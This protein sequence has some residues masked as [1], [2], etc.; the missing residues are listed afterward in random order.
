[1]RHLGSLLLS[2]VGGALIYVLI[3]IGLIKWTDGFD[4]GDGKDWAAFGIGLAAM[5]GAGALYA[6]LVLAR[7]SPL[8]LVLLGLLFLAIP[9]WGF[10][11]DS[12]FRDVMP[13][14]ILVDG[15]GWAAAK[16][17]ILV[18]AALPLLATIVS[19]RRWRRW[20]S[21]P[22]AVAP[23][24]NYSPPPVAP[25]TSTPAYQPP[26]ATPSYSP[27]QSTGYPPQSNF[28]ASS[29]PS[30][31]PSSAP[32]HSPV[33]PAYGQPVSPAYGQPVSPAYGAPASPPYGGGSGYGTPQRHGGD[34]GGIA[35]P[36]M[37]PAGPVG[38]D[39]PEST[40]RL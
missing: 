34:Q 4:A 27:P 21:A 13:R 15:A 2:L 18:L 25:A 7:L 36:P 8:G 29:P 39:D 1:M 33:S 30:N 14:K 19:P 28:P 24:P 12:S 22:A 38:G 35:F 5:L 23:Q 10:F 11:D 26:S 32:P 16:L 20:G 40:R 17:P 9:L 3:G 6:L 37:P 31:Y